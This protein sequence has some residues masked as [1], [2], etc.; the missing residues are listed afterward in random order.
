[1]H[2]MPSLLVLGLIAY[3]SF[4]GRGSLTEQG[5]VFGERATKNYVAYL[6]GGSAAVLTQTWWMAIPAGVGT[7]VLMG[8]GARMAKHLQALRELRE[9]NDRVLQRMQGAWAMG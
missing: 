4:K 8:S 7:R 1:M 5:R 2:Y 9:A 6:V 3:M